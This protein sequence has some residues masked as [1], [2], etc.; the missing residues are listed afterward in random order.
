MKS[1]NLL[2]LINHAESEV[3]QLG[4][5]ISSQEKYSK[6]WDKL[7]EYCKDRYTDY[8]VDIGDEFLEE[9][10]DLSNTY[11]LGKNNHDSYRAVMILNSYMCYGKIYVKYFL[12]KNKLSKFYQDL[13]DEFLKYCSDI[14]NNAKKTQNYKKYATERLLY[15][16]ENGNITDFNDINFE[17]ITKYLKTLTDL[18]HNSLKL[19]IYTLRSFLI[20]LY[21]TNRTNVDLQYIIPKVKI[22][23][24]PAIPSVWEKEDVKKIIEAIDTSNPIGKRDYAM[25]L[26]V[27]KLGIRVM[28]LKHLTIDNIDWKKKE[29]SFIMSKT[30]KPQNL[31]LPNDVGW[32]IIDYLKNGRPICDSKVIFIR[33]VK[34]I[35]PFDDSDSLYGIIKKYIKLANVEFDDDLHK[36]GMHSLRHSLATNLLKNNIPINSISSI[37]GHDDKSSVSYYLKIDGDKLRECC[38]RNDDYGI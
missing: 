11:S 5:S 31:P 35:R 34:P 37:L 20:F 15:L 17:L 27:A 8:T 13:L 26:L 7:K 18:S 30:K 3:K 12:K 1:Q 36:K 14:K 28:D 4:Y 19:Y 32:A 22:P 33:H 38:G 24:Y 23:K 6:I 25:I 16:L 2:E 9:V 10:Y 21:K 29:I